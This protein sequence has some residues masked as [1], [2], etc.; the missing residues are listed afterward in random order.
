MENLIVLNTVSELCDLINTT[1]L[2]TFTNRVAFAMDLLAYARANDN[3][4]YIDEDL[5]FC[6][7]GGWIEIDDMGYVVAD[8]AIC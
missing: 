4:V 7:D 1:T 8:F 3:V 2:T 6:D 5:G